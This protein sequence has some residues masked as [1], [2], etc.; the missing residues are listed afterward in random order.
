M[1]SRVE[2]SQ[3]WENE[4]KVRQAKAGAAQKP[5]PRPEK[6]L[7]DHEDDEDEDSNEND[8]DWLTQYRS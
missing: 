6:L 8:D 5:I 3:R 2:N 7:E 1:G 4:A